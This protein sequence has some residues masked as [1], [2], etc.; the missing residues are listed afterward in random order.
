MYS[1][2]ETMQKLRVTIQFLAVLILSILMLFFVSACGS[3]SSGDSPNVESGNSG[4]NDDVGSSTNG[5]SNS[6]ISVPQNL[7]ID[8][9]TLIWDDVDSATSYI[10]CINENEYAVSENTYSLDDLQSGTTYT[11]KIMAKDEDNNCSSW[12]AIL[13]Y[14]APS[15][16]HITKATGF[17]INDDNLFLK[18]SNDT[19]TF[20]FN[21]VIEVNDGSSWVLSN[22]INGENCII[23]KRVELSDVGDKNMYI[24]VY[25]ENEEQKVYSVTIRR[26]AIYSVNFVIGNGQ[27]VTKNVEEDG[28]VSQ[29]EDS[30]IPDRFGFEFKGYD[31]DF[32]T[33]IV[34]DTTIT[35]CWETNV[36]YID[37]EGVTKT[38]ENDFK[39]LNSSTEDILTGW[40][41]LAEDLSTT[42]LTVSGEAHIILA[43]ES[44]LSLSL[45]CVP[46]GSSLYIYAQSTSENAG[47]LKA[48]YI[49]GKNGAM[50]TTDTAGENGQ[51]AGSIIFNGGIITASHIGGGKGGS[52]ANGY[53]Y[54]GTAGTAGG[55]GGN[56]EA[57]VINGGN[58]SSTSIGGGVGGHGGNGGFGSTGTKGS[59]GNGTSGSAG[60]S[61]GSGGR[62]GKGGNGGNIGVVTINGGVISATYLGGGI[63]GNGGEGG[64]GGTG[65][66]GGKGRGKGLSGGRGGTGGTG[67]A[68][69][70]AGI[71]GNNGTITIN[72]G[73]ITITNVGGGDGGVG[74]GGGKGGTG[75]TGGTGSTGKSSTTSNGGT[76]GTGGSGGTGGRGAAG[77]SGGTGGNCG[78]IIIN[79]GD[80]SIKTI[81][82][83]N[84]KT[85]GDGGGGGKGGTGGTGGRGGSAS[86]RGC[87]GGKGGNGGSGGSGGN[88][89]NAANGGK[90][91]NGGDIIIIGGNFKVSVTIG[92]GKGG[93]GG[94]SWSGWSG[95]GG[96]GGS[97][98]S[99]TGSLGNGTKGTQPNN[100]S[101]KGS[102]GSAGATGSLA[103]I[104]VYEK[105]NLSSNISTTNAT[106]YYYSEEK[107]TSSGNYWHFDENESKP[108]IWD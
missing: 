31:F 77:G 105:S 23:T 54:Y 14:D 75:G 4:Y 32:S 65:G 59:N 40:Y 29:L 51:S 10:V 11:I 64:D 94:Q 90:G 76:G 85:G 45:L 43:D 68:G 24:I 53:N 38:I 71:G 92:G 13:R 16:P 52:G 96:A 84:G 60:S 86:G 108:I 25:N 56:V 47:K 74:G 5:S 1:K 19:T 63:G 44:T 78:T 9:T 55:N 82:A 3:N 57:I 26:R 48:T 87:R 2:K 7:R 17:S 91:G 100:Y 30:Q 34:T 42:T 41:F 70:S 27:E 103:S 81:G 50:G 69:G 107:P 93:T 101:T 106:V 80:L 49:G 21:E 104:F 15:L 95:G 99:G 73:V 39:A 28:F 22:D 89:G 72:D 62:G 58:I 61:G 46:S 12:S 102:D 20:D 67:G 97:G 6:T 37:S 33:P 88:G 79:G 98:G 8:G 83:G 36:Y 66:T 35:L 18:V